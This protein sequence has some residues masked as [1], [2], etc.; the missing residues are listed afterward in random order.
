[1]EK[2]YQTMKSKLLLKKQK[3]LPNLWNKKVH[4]IPV[5][6]VV[7]RIIVVKTLKAIKKEVTVWG[8]KQT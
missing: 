6:F 3:R 8:E 5:R 4:V 1:M 2:P 7:N